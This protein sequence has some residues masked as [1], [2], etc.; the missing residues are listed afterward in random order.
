VFNL[1]LLLTALYD[2]G[3]LVA[4]GVTLPP[5]EGAAILPPLPLLL[6]LLLPLVVCFLCFGFLVLYVDAGVVVLLAAEGSV[7]VGVCAI[8]NGAKVATGIPTAKPILRETSTALA[9]LVIL[10]PHIRECC[11]V[12]IILSTVVQFIIFFWKFF[13]LSRLYNYNQ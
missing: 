8:T 5:E 3:E 7:G 2:Y 6:P 1:G 11:V 12:V 13:L 9:N 4:A 10:T